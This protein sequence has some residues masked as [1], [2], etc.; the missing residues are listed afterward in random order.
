MALAIRIQ[1]L[2]KVY[3]LGE[4]NRGLFIHDWMRKLRGQTE[5]VDRADPKVFWALRDVS[6]DVEEGD[7][8]GLLGRNGA[9]KST[10]LKLISQITAPTDGTIKLRGRAAALLEVGTG[11]H[12]EL[13]GRDNIFINGAILGMT[14]REIASKLDEIID[15]SGIES[16]IDTPVKRYSVGMRVRLA[17][18]IAAQLDTE[19]LILDEV[20]A[21]GDAAFQQKCLGR[22]GNISRSGR[23]VLFVSHDAAAIEALCT[24]GIVLDQGKI[25]FDGTQTDA[26]EHYASLRATGAKSL[27]VR[28]DRAGSGQVRVNAIELRDTS[29]LPMAAVRSGRPLEVVLHFQRHAQ[30]SFPALAVELTVSTHLGAPVFFHSSWLDGID[31]DAVPESGQFVCQFPELPLPP[32]HYHIG[33]Q[34]TTGSHRRR[35]PI[36]A[37]PDAIELHVEPGDFYGSGKLPPAKSGVCLVHG[38]WRMEPAATPSME[39][40]R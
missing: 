32:G 35:E 8:V 2:S 34:L 36:D 22:I 18:A 3:R 16:F 39:A 13:T 38:A 19:I 21:V 11:F 12:H 28:T 33:Y 15:F 40:N 25:V 24:R 29:R 26:I 14:R 30:S 9:G 1:N 20:L 31:F 23:T 27:D 10:L 4:L 37:L 7:V 6:F 17:F 5:E